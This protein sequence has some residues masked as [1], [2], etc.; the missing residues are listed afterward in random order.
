MGSVNH[1]SWSWEN[2]IYVS[3]GSFPIYTNTF[4]T[5][6]PPGD[7]ST[8]DGRLSYKCQVEVYRCLLRR[9]RNIF[10]NARR[11]Y[12]P[13]STNSDVITQ[14][15]DDN[16]PEKMCIFTICIDYLG[17]VIPPGC[18]EV[19]T[20]TIDVIP[21]FCHPTSL[22]GLRKLLRLFNA[23]HR[24]VPSFARAGSPLN[25]KVRKGEPQTFG[26]LA[27]HGISTLETLKAR[28]VEPPLLPLPRL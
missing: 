19:S 9:L 7:F 12:R 22:T 2:S 20:I 4:W 6:N 1:P 26:G 24:S 23:F 3:P 16:R 27:D 28:L 25:Q 5:L 18:L 10:A 21:I 17:R 13:C 8:S 11:S 15:L 14:Y